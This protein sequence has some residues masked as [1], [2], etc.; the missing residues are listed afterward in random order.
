LFESLEIIGVLND[1]SANIH[2][3]FKT[4]SHGLIVQADL[5]IAYYCIITENHYS[6][7]WDT[8]CIMALKHDLLFFWPRE[9]T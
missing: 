7:K 1:L 5:T 6:E 2:H 9:R 8:I 3:G 4:S